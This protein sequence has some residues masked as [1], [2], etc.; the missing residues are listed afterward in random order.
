LV[1][2]VWRNTGSC[3]AESDDL[4]RRVVVAMVL[5]ALV[6]AIEIWAYSDR[7][8]VEMIDHTIAAMRGSMVAWST[9]G[10]RSGR[11]R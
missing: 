3:R 1:G 7:R 5:A 11:G 4:E 8:L 2:L 6:T 10:M 9:A